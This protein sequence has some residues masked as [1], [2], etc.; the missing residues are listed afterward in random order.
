MYITNDTITCTWASLRVKYI[1]IVLDL[2]SIRIY[3]RNHFS[4]ILNNGLFHTEKARFMEIQNLHSVEFSFCY[5][6]LSLQFPVSSQS[7]HFQW[8]CLLCHPNSIGIVSVIPNAYAPLRNI[9]IGRSLTR[10]TTYIHSLKPILAPMR[11]HR[12]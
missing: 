1:H 4:K 11:F 7:I 3:T 2:Y 12:D 9:M 6:Y 8:S 10:R 5:Y